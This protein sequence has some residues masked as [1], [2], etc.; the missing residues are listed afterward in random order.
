MGF[1]R[2]AAVAVALV[3]LF[4]GCC[5]LSPQRFP[6]EAF[7][8]GN[9]SSVFFASLAGAHA[10]PALSSA[11]QVLSDGASLESDF[12]VLS[13]VSGAPLAAI[14]SAVVYSFEGEN[15]AESGALAEGDF[16]AGAAIERLSGNS[17]WRR[18]DSGGRT[19]YCATIHAKGVCAA[20]VGG[21]LAVG[22]APA[23]YAAMDVES[24][25]PSISSNPRVQ[26][27]LGRLGSGGAFVF[28]KDD[29]A[30]SFSGAPFGAGAV[31]SGTLASGMSARD[32]NGSIVFEGVLLYGSP[33]EAGAAALA[34]NAWASGLYGFAEPGGAVQALLSRVGASSEG[35]FA[36]IR[37]EAS[38]G[39]L[40]AAASEAARQAAERP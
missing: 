23:V 21:Y 28:A 7:V 17:S 39:E 1:V 36:V 26:P 9:S 13:E 18:V 11:Y 8:P 40:E 25:A 27:V 29:Y 4:S 6:M 22:S 20:V 12:G 38:P 24:G 34:V 33:A 37:L 19:I 32:A 3:A 16:D 30:E 35:N 31:L 2:S 15:G 5:A 14:S 10:S